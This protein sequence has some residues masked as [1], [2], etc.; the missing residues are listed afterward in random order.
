MKNG[1]AI[2]PA[3]GRRLGHGHGCRTVTSSDEAGL[4]ISPLIKSAGISASRR[5]RQREPGWN[6]SAPSR[7]GD[8]YGN[9]DGCTRSSGWSSKPVT[10]NRPRSDDP[11]DSDR[12]T[13]QS[14]R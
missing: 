11:D 8:R 12:A 6:N 5:A 10:T 13:D 7:A 4:E 3:M 1:G 2:R 9:R 14:S